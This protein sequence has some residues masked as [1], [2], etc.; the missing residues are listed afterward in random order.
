MDG[1]AA[2]LAILV[3][4]SFAPCRDILAT[5]Y[6]RRAGGDLSAAARDDDHLGDGSAFVL[7]ERL[8][9]PPALHAVLADGGLAAALHGAIVVASASEDERE[10]EATAAQPA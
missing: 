9:Q 10:A 1:I 6:G 5:R 7:Q 2:L 4:A 3:V 8:D